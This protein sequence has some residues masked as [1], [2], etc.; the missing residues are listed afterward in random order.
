MDSFLRALGSRIRHTISTETLLDTKLGLHL[1][2]DEDRSDRSDN[3]ELPEGQA[4]D[5]SRRRG[6]KAFSRGSGR[7]DPNLRC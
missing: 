2:L 4:S 3:P 1:L 5:A 7:R 6:A